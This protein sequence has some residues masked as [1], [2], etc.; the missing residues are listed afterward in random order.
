MRH[1]RLKIPLFLSLLAT[2]ITLLALPDDRN[3][4][5][6]LE[7]DRAQLD[8]RTGISVYQ[9]NVVITQGSMRLTADNV[10]IY[11][12]DGNF[13]R[14]EAVGKPVTLRYK[15][16][17]NT[18]EINGVSKRVEYNAITAQVV[19]TTNAK[20]TQGQ[21]IF[22]GDRIEYDLKEDLVKAQGTPE[23]GRIQFILQPKTKNK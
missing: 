19:M 1:L 3:Q 17:V 8:Q 22:I 10:T 2:P 12:Q 23:G 5:I 14:M 13:Q 21:D 9:G 15:P 20:I 6:Q 16:A 4:P 7:A 18:E 11:L